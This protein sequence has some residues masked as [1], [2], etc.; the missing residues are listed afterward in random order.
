MLIVPSSLDSDVDSTINI[1]MVIVGSPKY[2]DG[3]SGK[4]PMIPSLRNGRLKV[5][6]AQPSYLMSN[7]RGLKIA[8]PYA[9][10]RP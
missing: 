6:E 9:A 7:A 1:A 3:D 2:R 5:G 10:Y 8:N 4:N